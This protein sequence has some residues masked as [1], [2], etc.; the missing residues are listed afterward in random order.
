MK[1]AK[2]KKDSQEKTNNEAIQ[3]KME[4]Q[5]KLTWINLTKYGK[6]TSQQK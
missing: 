2:N 4:E 1:P 5:K 3:S 6:Y